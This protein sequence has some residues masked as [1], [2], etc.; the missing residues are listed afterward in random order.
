MR[1]YGR[2]SAVAEA[3]G[4]QQATA[5]MQYERRQCKEDECDLLADGTDS[6]VER[7]GDRPPEQ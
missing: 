5:D 1:Q 7:T 2:L 3:E 4:P 6:M